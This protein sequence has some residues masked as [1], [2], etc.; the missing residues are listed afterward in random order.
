MGGGVESSG[1]EETNIFMLHVLIFLFLDLWT[2]SGP[3]GSLWYAINYHLA[4]VLARCFIVFHFQHIYTS[5]KRYNVNLMR[6]S[7]H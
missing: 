4:I 5:D 3:G 6:F 1:G 2:S 7:Y